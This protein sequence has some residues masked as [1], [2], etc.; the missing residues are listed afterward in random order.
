[1]EDESLW[2]NMKKQVNLP[3]RWFLPCFM[4]EVNSIKIL[5]RYHEDFMEYEPL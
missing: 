5:I 3:W 2:I 4:Q 1:M